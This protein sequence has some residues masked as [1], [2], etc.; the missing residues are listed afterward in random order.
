MAGDFF[1][2]FACVPDRISPLLCWHCRQIRSLY[3][4]A[5]QNS[6]CT[7]TGPQRK[8]LA[9]PEVRH[10]KAIVLVGA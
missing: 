7:V 2:S 1:V 10:G 4:R 8:C 6:S 5:R 9:S 3:A